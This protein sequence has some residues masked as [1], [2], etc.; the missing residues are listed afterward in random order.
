[1]FNLTQIHLNFRTFQSK[2]RSSN[3][4]RA[5]GR[6]IYLLVTNE[7]SV[8]PLKFRNSGTKILQSHQLIPELIQSQL[9]N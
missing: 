6:F 7:S 8:K 1:M 4:S 2:N 9:T 5:N 3:E